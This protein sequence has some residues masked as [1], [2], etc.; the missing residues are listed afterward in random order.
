M[1]M[2]VLSQKI[3]AGDT[4]KHNGALYTVSFEAAPDKKTGERRFFISGARGQKTAP[5]SEV[6]VYS[7]KKGAWSPFVV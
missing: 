1:R 2:P 4:V 6:E 7:T 5:E 3:N